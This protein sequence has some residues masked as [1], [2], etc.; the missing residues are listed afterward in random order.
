MAGIDFFEKNKYTDSSGMKS[1]KKFS[2]SASI[3]DDK[4]KT[5]KWI[6]IAIAAVLLI[7]IVV[8]IID[9]ARSNGTIE[10]KKMVVEHEDIPASFSGYKILQISDINGKEFG[11][12]QS[13]LVAL[14]KGL[15][16]DMILLTGDYYGEDK[17][18]P[19]AVLDIIDGL[20]TD[21]PI[22]YV[23]GEED[24]PAKKTEDDDWMMCIPVPDDSKIAAEFAE[25][26]VMPVYPAQR[27][28]SDA[29]EYIY[30]TG[31]KNSNTLKGFDFEAETD[32]SICVSHK[33]IDYNVDARL[34][35]VN[36][37]IITEID[38]DLNIAGHTLG[39][40]YRLPVLDTVYTDDYGFFPQE[41][42][43]YGLSKDSSGRYNYISGGLGV[44]SGFRMGI[45]PEVSIIELKAVG[46]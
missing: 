8:W 29:G 20:K 19:W 46:K 31:I 41:K 30:L 24:V 9:V 18:D 21:K 35:D 36:T 40:Q 7:C 13:E 1:S 15:K 27:I 28:E 33:P 43:V 11:D 14:I 23:L 37:R 2:P 22:Y 32:F 42:Q 25:R 38:Y 26:G 3:F 5:R 6:L 16:F 44:K 39:G 34:R 4:K 45:C 12:R 17:N 10:V